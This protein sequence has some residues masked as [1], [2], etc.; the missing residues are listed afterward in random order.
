MDYVVTEYGI[1]SLRGT[2]IRERVKALINIA[3]PDFREELQ[4]QANEFMIW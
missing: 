1:A 4:R 2:S 3:Q